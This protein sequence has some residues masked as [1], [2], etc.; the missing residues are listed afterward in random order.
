MFV[1]PVGSIVPFAGPTAPTCWLLC[2]GS[3]KLRIDFPA[4][5]A[6]ISVIYGAEDEDH[7][8]VPDLRGR[9]PLGVSPGIPESE[10]PSERLLATTGGQENH[11][12]TA[13]ES[14]LPAHNHSAYLE[15]TQASEVEAVKST[16]AAHVYDAGAS[17]PTD[18]TTQEQAS[19]PHNTM[20]PFLTL[21]FLIKT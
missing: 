6:I 11:L 1:M 16:C 3:S 8:T 13:N 5:F 12:N 15:G 21:N 4:L 14:A 18:Q 2:D 17:I 10:R 19:T 20:H 7:F 9:S